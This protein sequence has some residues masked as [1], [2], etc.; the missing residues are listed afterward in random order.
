MR[1]Y[2]RSRSVSVR[3]SMPSA[4]FVTQAGCSRPLLA[5]LDQAEPAG[6]DVAESPSKWQSVGIAIPASRAASR[7]VSPS[8]ALTSLPSIVR[9]RTDILITSVANRADRSCPA[10]RRRRL[11][12]S[13]PS[14]A[15]CT[16]GG[17]NRNV[18]RTGLGAVWPRP[19]R[20]V[21]LTMSQSD[22]SRSRSR[23]VAPPASIRV[24]QPVHLHRARPAR[25][26]LAARFVRAEFHEEFR[27]FH[28]A[29]VLVHDDHAA[30]A[31]DR[32]ERLAATRNRPACRAASAGMQPPDGPPVCTALIV[33]PSGA[34][35]PI[36]STI[37]P[38][39]SCPSALRRGPYSSPCRSGRRPWSP[40]SSSVPMSANHSAPLRR[41]AGTLAN[42]STL[43]MQRRDSPRGPTPPGTAGA[44]A[45]CRA[46]PRSRRSAPSPRRR[47]TPRRRCAGRSES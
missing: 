34:P 46:V 43:L 44:A 41:I 16:R 26:A 3:T 32:A 17:S 4:T 35:P 39:R 31:H 2:S 47:Q 30:G 14:R 38:Q 18:L 12:G 10:F 45:A 20:L 9:V 22:S 37:V 29:R 21:C 5:D 33:P 1:R 27:D 11:H 19:H 25:D 42:V 36:S 24:E 6:G 8:R 15:R 40:C 28:H 7:I 23:R 13:D